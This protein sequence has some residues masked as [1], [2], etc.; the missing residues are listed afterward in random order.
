MKK[1]AKLVMID[2]D[3]KYLLMYRSDHPTFGT[4]PDLPGGTLE[5]GETVL[6]TMIREVKEETG[7]DIHADSVRMVY[8]GADYSSHGTH[9]ALFVS[10]LNS[11]PTI[12]MS[13]EHSGFEWLN[14]DDFLK[15][16]MAAKDTYMHM[17]ADV[18]K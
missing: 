11:R 7:V 15:K 16:A 9:Y 2:P 12:N 13:W 8:S 6:N 3:G 18:L 14:S 4:D 10:N 17:V 1:V 5:D